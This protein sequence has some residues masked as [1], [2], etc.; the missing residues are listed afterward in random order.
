[1]GI[2]GRAS[3]GKPR[4]CCTEEAVKGGL[5]QDT[6]KG[7][8]IMNPSKFAGQ[9]RLMTI[10]RSGDYEGSLQFGKFEQ[11]EGNGRYVV[12]FA[13]CNDEG[14]LLTV[15]GKTIWKSRHGYLPGNLFGL[16][17]FL[18]F[19]FFIYFAML[20]WFG[21]S[22][23]MFED[24]NI[25]IQN[26]IFATISMGSLEL[27]FRTGD[28]FVWNED[29]TRFWVAFYVGVTVACLKNGISRCLL[30]MVSLGWGVIRDD[31]GSVMSKITFLG[32]TFT[33]VSLLH[34]IMDVV[35]YTEVQKLSEEEEDELFD[36]VEIL[37][38]VIVV[39]DVIFVIWILDAM[40]GTMEYLENMNQTS[41]LLRYLRLRF[42][43]LFA[44]L[45]AIA[46]TVFGVVDQVD[47]GIVDHE[48]EWVLLASIELDY[49]F[50]LLGV[51][52]L[53]RPQENAKEYAYV[54]ELPVMTDNLDDD[55]GEGEL[56]LSVVVPSA[57]NGDEEE[58]NDEPK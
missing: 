10:P 47:Q 52:T 5:C 53:W 57:D 4:Y 26:W 28:L 15:F 16:M 13:N 23:K 7:R 19:L 9:H 22:M 25:P 24:A 58:F 42:I 44:I 3:D 2:G 50:V 27:F 56:E 38:I 54:M 34:D 17:Y 40:N 41:K 32:G 6:Q 33:A 14:R 20:L 29:G 36:I 45:F 30:V 55:A 31:L 11:R 46:Y 49:V 1:L 51:A 35:A 18:A 12:V 21:V 8:L 39:L 48:Q 37:G 43:L